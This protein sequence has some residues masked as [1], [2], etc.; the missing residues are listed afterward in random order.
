MEYINTYSSVV[1]TDLSDSLVS[2]IVVW[3]YLSDSS[4]TLSGGYWDTTR[5]TWENGKYIWSK[6]VTTYRDKSTTESEPVCITGAMGS[7]GKGVSSITPEYYLSDSKNVQIGGEWKETPD[8]WLYGKYMWTRNKIIYVNPSSTEYTTPIC[9]S[10]WDAANQVKET[11]Q[12]SISEVSLKVDKQ[13]EE[14]NSKISKTDVVE[15]YEDVPNEDGDIVSTKTEEY[16]VDAINITSQRLEGTRTEISNTNTKIEDVRSSMDIYKTEIE[17]SVN[18]IRA[19]VSKVSIVKDNTT[20]NEISLNEFYNS[21]LQ[22]AEGQEITIRNVIHNAVNDS[23]DT[24]GMELSTFIKQTAGSM[25]TQ[26]VTNDDF[27]EYKNTIQQS[28]ERVSY[29]YENY[30][31]PGSTGV[32]LDINGITV[33]RTDDNGNVVGKSVL[34][35]KGL[36]GYTGTDE[37]STRIFYLTD[38]GSGQNEATIDTGVVNLKYS[39]SDEIPAFRTEIQSMVHSGQTRK[40][41]VLIKP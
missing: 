37:N 22:T 15:I 5:P 17:E 28:S 6:T 34:G 16:I 21:Y 2:S 32:N 35:S 4:Q 23:E 26:Y 3:Y 11:L 41:L 24:T 27:G 10:S 1:V 14:I 40:I 38:R 36:E 33:Y 31:T 12:S 25:M 39:A 9:D 20:G 7:T 8:T 19:D 29:L 30:F 18:G 13:T